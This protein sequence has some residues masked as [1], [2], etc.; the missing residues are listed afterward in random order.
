M[1]AWDAVKSVIG[2]GLRDQA[3]PRTFTMVKPE[4]A[5]GVGGNPI[6]PHRCYVKVSIARMQLKDARFLHKVYYPIVHSFVELSR[7]GADRVTI[8]YVAGPAQ[9]SDLAKGSEEVVLAK[10]VDVCGPAPYIGGEINV[11]IGLCAAV[12]K[13]YLDN[14]LGVLGSLS[15]VVGGTAL[16]SALNVIEPLKSSAESLLGR[17]D[18]VQLKVGLINTFSPTGVASADGGNTNQG[19]LLDGFYALVNVDEAEAYGPRLH[20]EDGQ[21]LRVDGDQRRPITEDHLV[22]QISQYDAMPDWSRFPALAAVRLAVLKAAATEGLEG[23]DYRKQ[24][25]AFKG[26][27][28]ENADLVA[29]D[30]VIIIRGL[31][32]EAKAYAGG[33]QPSASRRGPASTTPSLAEGLAATAKRGP[34]VA[35]AWSIELASL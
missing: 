17:S 5:G 20:F 27:V 29:S 8:P 3:Q 21:L 18:D 10:N 22:F 33:P 28:L 7:Q 35:E 16:T 13:D 15:G 19:Q 24:F 34:S 14:L 30:R 25:G 4:N 26:A 6:E 9:L 31:E 2:K 23:D 1:S 32:E 12:A 11:A